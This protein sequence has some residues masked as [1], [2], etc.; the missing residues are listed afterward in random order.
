METS[1]NIDINDKWYK[2]KAI[3]SAGS[4]VTIEAGSQVIID[5]SIDLSH[6]KPH[7]NFKLRVAK[8]GNK[9]KGKKV[10][11]IFREFHFKEI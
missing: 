7:A 1:N 8:E 6:G 4:S 9:P 3:A 5:Y 2:G 10:E 11:K